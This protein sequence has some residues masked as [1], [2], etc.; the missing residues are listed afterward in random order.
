M[1]GYKLKKLAGITLI[2]VLLLAII[3]AISGC[4]SP[5]PTTTPNATPTAAPNTTTSLT[6]TPGVLK[7]A[8]D[9]HYAPFENVNSTTGQIEGFDIDL[10]NEIAKELN[11]TPTYTD[12]LFDG[13]ILSVQT[14][15]YDCSI[16]AFTITGERQKTIDFSDPYYENKGQSIAVKPGSTITK[17]ADLAGKKIAVQQGTVGEEAVRNIT[18][19]KAE[20]VK[21]YGLMPDVMMSLK[22]GEVDAAAGDYAVMYPYVKKYPGDYVFAPETLSDVEYFG[23][24]LNKDNKELTSKVNAA[25]KKIKDDGRYQTIYDRWFS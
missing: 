10:M 13:I 3:V 21:S 6:L 20:D 22:K 5:T 17:P 4:T 25:L 11:L 8:S 2:A 24:V 12:Q 15:Q 16:S 23:I 1:G 7:V 9:A 19:V 18:G 14:K